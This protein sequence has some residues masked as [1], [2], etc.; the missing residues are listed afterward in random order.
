[1]AD[2]RRL[3]VKSPGQL[4][5]PVNPVARLAENSPFESHS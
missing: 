1:M 2:G 3:Y 5:C 4:A